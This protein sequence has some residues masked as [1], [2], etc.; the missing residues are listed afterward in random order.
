MA[1]KQI[2]LLI[3]ADQE[4]RIGVIKTSLPQNPTALSILDID[5]LNIVKALN[6]ALSDHFDCDHRDVVIN[7]LD[8]K[9]RTPLKIEVNCIIPDVEDCDDEI[10]VSLEEIYVYFN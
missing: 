5:A 2:Y 8:I 1:K 10:I 9:S 3:T 7:S 6:T 4:P